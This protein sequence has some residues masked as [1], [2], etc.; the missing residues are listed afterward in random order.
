MNDIEILEEF[1]EQY[2]ASYPEEK[3]WVAIYPNQIEA[4]ENLIQRNKDLEQIEKEYKGE[5]MKASYIKEEL[6]NAKKMLQNINTT[7]YR[8]RE[9]NQTL[10]NQAYNILD[11]LNKEID[12]ECKK[13]K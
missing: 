8:K 3:E 7:D 10:I 12:E 1:I 9:Y 2:N 13:R 6:T 5:K 11:K 4:I